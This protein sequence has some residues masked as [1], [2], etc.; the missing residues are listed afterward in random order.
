MNFLINKKVKN[1]KS[2]FTLIEMLVSTAIF[3]SVMVVAIGA[4]LSIINSNRKAQ[5]I[6][7]VVDN[8]NFAIESISRDV[9][10][11][12]DYSCAE[13]YNGTEFSNNCSEG[14]QKIHYKKT[15]ISGTRL[16]ESH[17]FYRFIPSENLLDADGNLQRCVGDSEEGCSGNDGWVSVTAPK[18]VVDIKNVVF[19]VLGSEDSVIGSRIQPRVIITAEGAVKSK[20]GS[21]TTFSLQTTASQRIRSSTTQNN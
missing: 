18:S 16:T 12:V 9:R 7:T 15:L 4:L 21:E 10:V 11:G 6:K 14:G 19:Y 13:F 5:D 20:D 3:M 2:G 8:V 17:V 1:K